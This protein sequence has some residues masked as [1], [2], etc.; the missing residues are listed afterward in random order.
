MINSIENNY[1]VVQ[2][3]SKTMENLAKS[4]KFKDIDLM[5]PRAKT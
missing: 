2:N 1:Q 4:G 5:S 3:L